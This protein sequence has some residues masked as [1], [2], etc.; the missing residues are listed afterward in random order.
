MSLW[1]SG[2]AEE[3]PTASQ[4]DYGLR[5]RDL[6]CAFAPCVQASAFTFCKSHIL[7]V[8]QDKKDRESKKCTLKSAL[9]SFLHL[10]R[11][12]AIPPRSAEAW[13]QNL[14]RTNCCQIGKKIV[15]GLY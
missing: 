10:Q 3:A 6:H 8:L 15:H 12:A 9:N 4:D 11:A 2:E 5:R 14:S 1:S 13:T 7:V